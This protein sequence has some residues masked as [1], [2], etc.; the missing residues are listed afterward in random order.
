MKYQIDIP[1]TVTRLFA[2]EENWEPEI[3][4]GDHVRVEV[5]ADNEAAARSRLGQALRALTQRAVR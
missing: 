5:E 4:M 3:V 1:C 2:G